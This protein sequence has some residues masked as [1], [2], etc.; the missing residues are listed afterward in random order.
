MGLEKPTT[1]NLSIILNELAEALGVANREIM[2]PE[3]Y[4]L[5]KYDEIKFMYDIVKQK[6]QLSTSE[7]Q[8]FVAELRAVRK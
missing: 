4:D 3:D 6:G 2:D 8:A 7:T 5:N 1:N